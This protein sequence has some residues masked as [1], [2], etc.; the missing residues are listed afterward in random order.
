MRRCA[1]VNCCIAKGLL[2]PA[3]KCHKV[4]AYKSRLGNQTATTGKKNTSANSTKL[5]KM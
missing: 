5:S 1:T 3:T 2:A 4:R